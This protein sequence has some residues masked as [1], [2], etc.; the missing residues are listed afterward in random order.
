VERK[1]HI[2][3]DV[4]VV[5]FKESSRPY[6][7][8]LIASQF[9]H[10]IIVVSVEEDARGRE[11]YRVAVTAKESVPAFPPRLPEGGKFYD[12]NELRDFLLQKSK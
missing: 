12:P 10:V 6:L 4:V 3:N 2:G 9:T 8:S 1:C 11:F 7:A 5:I